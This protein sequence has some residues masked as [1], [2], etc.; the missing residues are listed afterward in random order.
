MDLAVVQAQG[1]SVYISH[2]WGR[3]QEGRDNHDRVR[4]VYQQLKDLGIAARFDEDELR[5]NSTSRGRVGI[6]QATSVG[7]FLTERYLQKA[8]AANDSC[9]LEFDTALQMH[10]AERMIVVVMEPRCR[11]PSAWTG[12]VGDALAGKT[13]IDLSVDGE[14]FDR[15]VRRIAEEIIAVSQKARESAAP[16]PI[17][18]AR[19]AKVE[20]PRG[21]EVDALNGL[22]DILEDSILEDSMLEDSV[23]EDSMLAESDALVQVRP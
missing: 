10:G 5:G 14:A 20:A 15:G 2:E 3:D 19:T 13:A 8:S 17:A 4:R 7:I 23:L 22:D 12:T 6:H 11:P 18:R 21:N 16:P 1:A 9:K